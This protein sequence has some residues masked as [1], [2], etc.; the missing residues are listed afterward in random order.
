MIGS[1]LRSANNRRCLV[2]AI[3]VGVLA[4]PLAAQEAVDPALELYYSA[5]AAYNRK[6]Y[7]VAIADYG[8]FLGRYGTHAK[9]QLARHGLGLSH[10]ALKQY[11]QA[12]PEFLKL[13]EERTLDKKIDHGRLSLLHVQCLLYT[14]KKDEALKRLIT[15]ATNLKPSV[16]RTGA[17]AGVADLYFE[18]KDWPNTIA[19]AKKL[20]GAGA[21]A[22]Q[23]IRAEYQEGF[24]LYKLK[25]MPEAIEVLDKAKAAAMKE[26]SEAWVT[27]IGYLLGECHVSNKSLD[28]GEAAL[29][30]ALLG[31]SGT[32]AVDAR[33]R[34]ATIKYS[35]EK[36]LNAQADFETFLKENKKPKEDD[37]RVRESLFRIARCLMQQGE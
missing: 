2:V 10:F 31:L 36:W 4:A 16:H 35:S 11:P 7:P 9:A 24:A 19:W 21:S 3:Y 12:A 22:G 34:L 33:Y 26:K 37:P 32:A 23:L 18:K 28:K 29:Q 27:R 8:K 17:I 20:K 25:K 14:D 13:L 1:L 6:L 15:A 30:E 5:N